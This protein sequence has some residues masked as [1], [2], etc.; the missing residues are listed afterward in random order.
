MGYKHNK[1]DILKKGYEIFR[2]SGYHNVGINEILKQSGLPKGSF[3]NFFESKEA[4]AREVID[5]YGQSTG[6]WLEGYFNNNSSHY[7]QIKK[8]YGYLIDAN[9]EDGYA[10]GCLINSMSNEIGTLNASLASISDHHFKGWIEII[11]KVIA[12]GQEAGEITIDFTALELAEYLHAGLY[13]T[14][15]R[16]KVTG[17]REYM[18]KWHTMTMKFI[19]R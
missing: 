15:A 4:F 8:F 1:E 18:D 2:K 11:A 13:G 19:K 10:S 5:Y 6:E 3:Y 16:M 9:E 14:F 7:A 17:S 12:K